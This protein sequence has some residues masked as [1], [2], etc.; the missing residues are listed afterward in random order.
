[1][2]PEEITQ[3]VGRGGG[4]RVMHIEKGAIRR[5]AESV[6]N[7][8]PL[9]WD[10]DYARNSKY[11]SIITV[12][13]FYGWPVKGANDPGFEDYSGELNAVL[14]K[15]GINKVL[16]GGTEFEYFAPVRAG[17]TL[18]ST[19]K[20]AEIIEREGRAGNLIFVITET[21]YLNQ[22]G[23]L[24]AKSRGTGIRYK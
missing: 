24:V 6:G 4:V 9:Y 16:N 19:S 22:H 20:I 23:E 3:F 2:L 15:N 10:E 7:T 18:S 13:G 21:T 12:P 8:N 14:A 11:G 17:D 5:F 1:M